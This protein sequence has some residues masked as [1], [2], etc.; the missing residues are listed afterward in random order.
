MQPKADYAVSQDKGVMHF[1]IRGLA[2]CAIA[3]DR[4]CVL[5]EYIS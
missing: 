3:K 2:M 5:Q 1:V 4:L